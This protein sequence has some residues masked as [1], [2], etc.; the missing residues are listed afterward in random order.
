M[1]WSRGTLDTFNNL[2]MNFGRLSD[3]IGYA[4]AMGW[5]YD[6]MHPKY[7]NHT[8]KDYSS[9]FAWKGKPKP[10]ESYD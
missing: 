2:Q 7:R 6:V 3:A 9:N 5:G 10:E 1:G 4:E 8:K